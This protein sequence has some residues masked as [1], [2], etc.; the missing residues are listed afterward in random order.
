[1]LPALFVVALVLTDGVL[2]LTR[3][4]PAVGMRLHTHTDDD[5]SWLP[6][7]ADEATLKRRFKALSRQLHPDMNKAAGAQ[8]QFIALTSEYRRLLG[9][10][11]SE[12]Q[13][14]QLE[15]SW[16]G[17]GG[18]GA[19][20]ALLFSTAPIVPAVVAAAV[21]AANYV[22]ELP[23]VMQRAAAD[24]QAAERSAFRAKSEAAEALHAAEK[25]EAAAAQRMHEASET[26]AEATAQ[27]ALSLVPAERTATAARSVS[28]A[29]ARARWWLRIRGVLALRTRAAVMRGQSS[30]GGAAKA[31]LRVCMPWRR[32]PRERA[33]EGMAVLDEQLRAAQATQA[34]ALIALRAAAAE[35][36]ARRA[37]ANAMEAAYAAATSARAAAQHAASVRTTEAQHASQQ[38]QSSRRRV[39]RW[40]A[41]TT[42]AKAVGR[43]VGRFGR[44]LFGATGRAILE[45]LGH[46]EMR[47]K[48]EDTRVGGTSTPKRV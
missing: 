26:Y 3:A 10:C 16:L 36:N 13:R 15:A 24:A 48:D 18:L 5:A 29:H 21:S 38:H 35:A 34:V 9:E 2:L 6:R 22:G 31:L 4:V 32:Q 1:M 11:R 25:A 40:H 37:E 46:A 44:A 41:T 47:E 27:W 12:Q 17:L 19:A 30:L 42:D 20:A 28:C 33:S 23:D 45:A 39:E 14:R 43:S 7:G 8:E